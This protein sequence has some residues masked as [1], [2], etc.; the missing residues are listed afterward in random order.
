MAKKKSVSLRFCT[1]GSFGISFEILIRYKIFFNQSKPS[2][3]SLD[4]ENIRF[5]PTEVLLHVEKNLGCH[6]CNSELDG[7]VY[8]A[9][10]NVY[11]LIDVLLK[12][13]ERA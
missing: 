1:S 13:Q 5:P 3:F 12:I 6:R 11:L 8:H 7:I 2:K 4:P 10:P 9:H